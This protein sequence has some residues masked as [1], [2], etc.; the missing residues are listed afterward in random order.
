MS[1]QDALGKHYDRLSPSERFTLDVE[2]QARGDETASRRLVDSCPRRNY[3][4]TD[5]AFS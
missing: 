3:S 4:M 5:W 1:K 2:A